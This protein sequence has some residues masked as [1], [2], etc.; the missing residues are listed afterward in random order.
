MTDLLQ[1]LPKIVM[2]R[3]ARQREAK[4]KLEDCC[5]ELEEK[6][7]TKTRMLLSNDKTITRENIIPEIT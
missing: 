7:T 2:P 1:Y 4:K 6:R 5:K 3:S